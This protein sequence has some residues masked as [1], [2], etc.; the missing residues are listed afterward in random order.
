MDLRSEQV[1]VG[2]EHIVS[3]RGQRGADLDLY[4]LDPL[5]CRTGHHSLEHRLQAGR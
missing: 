4:S 3:G 5:G 2:G 1:T